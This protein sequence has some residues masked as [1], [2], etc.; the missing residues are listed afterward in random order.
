MHGLQKKVLPVNKFVLS[1]V[2]FYSLCLMVPKVDRKSK[3]KRGSEEGREES[4]LDNPLHY[5]ETVYVDGTALPVSCCFCEA[6]KLFPTWRSLAKHLVRTHSLNKSIWKGTWLY[7]QVTNKYNK[8]LDMGDVE[9]NSIAPCAGDESRFLCKLCKDRSLSKTSFEGH[10]K[11]KHPEVDVRGWV[12]VKESRHMGRASALH[13]FTTAHE[14][15]ANKRERREAGES[16]ALPPAR[17]DAI[18]SYPGTPRSES[19]SSA[20]LG[21]T[22]SCPDNPLGRSPTSQPASS[23]AGQSGDTDS[24]LLALRAQIEKLTR[25]MD[26]GSSQVVEEAC[27]TYAITAAAR[28]WVPSEASDPERREWPLTPAEY[29]FSSF[30]AFLQTTKGHQPETARIYVQKLQ[31][32][33]GL[34]AVKG[35]D[36]SF[37]GLVASLYKDDVFLQLLELPILQPT[38]PNTR[39][40]LTSFEHFCDFLLMICRKKNYTEA[41]RCIHNLKVVILSP[42]MKKIYKERDVFTLKKEER[43][44]SKFHKLPPTSVLQDAVKQSM[45]DLNT[46]WELAQCSTSIDR[47]Y[48]YAAN[49]I[50][51]GIIY[52]NSYAGRPGEWQGLARQKVVKLVSEGGHVL[53]MEKHKTMKKFGT[54]GR[55]VPD[56]NLMAMRKVLDIHA[57]SNSLFFAPPVATSKMKTVSASKMLK[58]WGTTYTRGYQYPGPTLQRKW[59]HTVA[60]DEDV[61]K[62]KAMQSLCQM[63][64]H[65]KQTG[66]KHYVLSNPKR[67]AEAARKTFLRYVGEPVAWPEA[68]ELA[69]NEKS[70][71]RLQQSFFTKDTKHRRAASTESSGSA[72]R[73]HAK[74]RAR[75]QKRKGKGS[76]A[77]AIAAKGT[78]E[79]TTTE[80]VGSASSPMPVTPPLKVR[81]AAYFPQPGAPEQPQT[82]P[83]TGVALSPATPPT[84]TTEIS[85]PP[86]PV[87]SSASAAASGHSPMKARGRQTTF[88]AEQKNW[89]TDRIDEI[90]YLPRLPEI[91][92]MLHKGM[93]MGV[94]SRETTQEQVRHVCRAYCTSVGFRTP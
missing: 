20:W 5:I 45:I 7:N 32:M 77:I 41:T 38:L 88:T 3:K 85:E 23:A 21:D 89:I 74:H 81:P 66:M 86:S 27:P 30:K 63:D 47:K 73:F 49:V 68:E 46:L 2:A 31:Y 53:T 22:D 83:T 71:T 76:R 43:D 17:T 39:Q 60:A 24:G 12:L 8:W 64:G 67:D 90:G 14:A 80:A 79:A 62:D 58:K 94:L 10:F 84:P 82:P 16:S 35:T 54:K 11:S 48:K 18:T 9:Y 65:S 4:P 61:A 29:D 13:Q 36:F 56:G 19:G 92:A 33:F 93:D 44:V 50:M 34:L 28:G 1:G 57:P 69:D 51:M 6:E 25:V 87:R 72:S 37:I 55:Y 70:L 59:F 91:R 40:L 26:K 15:H 78:T 42:V 75:P 52:T